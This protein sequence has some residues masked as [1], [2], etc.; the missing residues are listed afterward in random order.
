MVTTLGR[1][2]SMITGSHEVTWLIKNDI[3]P[4][5]RGTW[6]PYLTRWRFTVKGH[7][8]L[9]LLTLWS[10]DQVTSY[11]VTDKK[12]YISTSARPMATK[13]GRVVGSNAGFLS[14]KSHNLLMTW[15]H[16]VT[17]Q[18]KN[19]LNSLLRD[20]SLLN[21]TEGWLMIRSQSP[22]TKPHISSITWLREFTRQMDFVI[23]LLPWGL[24]L[25]N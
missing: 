17:W 23:S 7:H 15:S 20:L 13:L 16:K 21:L 10:R 14:I 4:L 12:R 3:S 25:L 18:M 24:L 2:D 9:S 6:L 19:I 1:L 5:P 8:P 11:H 22:T